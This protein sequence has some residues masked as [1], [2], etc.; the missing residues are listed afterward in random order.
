MRH[1]GKRLDRLE[2]ESRIGPETV[3]T[4]IIEGGTATNMATGTTTTWAELDDRPVAA[5]VFRIGVLIVDPIEERP[6]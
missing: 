1:I 5:H 2:G 3:E 6:T 4:W